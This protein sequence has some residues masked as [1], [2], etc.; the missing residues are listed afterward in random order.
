MAIKCYYCS[1]EACAK[2][3]DSKGS[4]W[5]ALLGRKCWKKSEF[6]VCR[7]HFMMQEAENTRCGKNWDPIRW[8]NVNGR[9]PFHDFRAIQSGLKKREARGRCR[10]YAQR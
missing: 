3:G 2:I 6:Y 1:S 4:I 9:R 10:G 5:A 7:K 8:M